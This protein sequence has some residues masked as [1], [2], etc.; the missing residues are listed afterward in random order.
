MYLA[1]WE[2]QDISVAHQRWASTEWLV[3]P[4]TFQHKMLLIDLSWFEPQ[5]LFIEKLLNSFLI[6]I[7]EFRKR[8]IYCHQQQLRSLS[9]RHSKDVFLPRMANTDWSCTRQGPP[10]IQDLCHNMKIH[11]WNICL[12]CCDYCSGHRESESVIA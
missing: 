1:S 7:S 6:Q 11:T 10:F 9:G 12:I 4:W 5:F 2:N 8:F 3:F